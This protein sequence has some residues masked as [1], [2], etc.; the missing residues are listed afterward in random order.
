MQKVTGIIAEF[1]PFHNGHKLLLDAAGD[2][3]IKVIVMSGNWMQRGEPAFVDKWTRTEMALANGADLVVE[4][5]LMSALQGA[6]FFATGA[7]NILHQ[8]GVD[9]ILFGSESDGMNY[10]RISDIYAKKSSEMQAFMEEL[11]ELM[12]YPLKAEKA[13]KHF[14][15]V[16]FDGNTPN[17]ILGLAYAKAVSGTEIKLRTVLRQTGYNE[18][19]LSGLIASATAI[20]QNFSEA[21]AFVPADT[22]N[23]LK[24]SPKRSWDDFWELLRY[25]V[26]V[27]SR[28]TNVYQ[29][30]EE[31]SARIK[32]Y[33]KTANNLQELIE[34]VY[35]KRYTKGHIR[36][37][38]TYILLDIPKSCPL[39]ESIHVLGFTVRGQKILARAR[40]R[41]VPLTTKIGQYPWDSLTQRA[42]EIYR[43]G[44]PEIPEQTYSRKPIIWN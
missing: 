43:L 6:D 36:R 9:E 38:L 42:D 27:S 44:N 10:Q 22:W 14:A 30:N 40:E 17:H 28:L 29:V 2:D 23:L 13:W 20:R 26:T 12:S 33:I 3:R 18:T 37:L 35:T 8:L 34:Q 24:S 39:P 1:N 5:P 4:L 16:E 15:G 41:E 7:V 21:S 32:K 19:E 25:K 11:P 31:L